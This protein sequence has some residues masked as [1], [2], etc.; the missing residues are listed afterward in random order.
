MGWKENS[1][2]SCLG[3]NVAIISIICQ[4]MFSNIIK[5]LSASSLSYNF[6]LV[7]L[8]TIFLP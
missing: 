7:I 3:R 4:N 8:N 1:F 6:A 5:S 2:I